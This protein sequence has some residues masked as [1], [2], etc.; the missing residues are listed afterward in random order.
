MPALP[1]MS[2][3]GPDA[4]TAGWATPDPVS[5]LFES[6]DQRYLLGNWGGKRVSLAEKGVT[7]DFFYISDMQ[8]TPNWWNS[9]NSSWLGKSS[10]NQI[11]FWSGT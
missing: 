1:Q 5:A 11:R 2:M 4:G 6:S 7:F 10:W 3:V 8:A 9:T